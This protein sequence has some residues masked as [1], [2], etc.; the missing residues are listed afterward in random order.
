MILLLL[1]ENLDLILINYCY[2]AYDLFN[3]FILIFLLTLGFV[4]LYAI[5]LFYLTISLY[6]LFL[7]LKFDNTDV[8]EFELFNDSRDY[9]RSLLLLFDNFELFNNDFDVL[10][11]NYGLLIFLYTLSVFYNLLT[12]P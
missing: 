6:L 4:I 10:R 9:K 11:N 1:Y 8:W 2:F 7:D 3:Y 5:I 12:N